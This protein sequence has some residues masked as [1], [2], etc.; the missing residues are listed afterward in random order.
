MPTAQPTSNAFVFAELLVVLLL[1]CNRLRRLWLWGKQ[2]PEI[3]KRQ[4]DTEM[5]LADK[6]KQ[7]QQR[8]NNNKR[9]TTTAA[10]ANAQ[11]RHKFKSN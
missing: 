4:I 9:T 6:C 2:K 10:Q 11:E 5:R 8:E 3:I 1:P 7:Q